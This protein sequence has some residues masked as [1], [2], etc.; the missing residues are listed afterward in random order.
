MI[1]VNTVLMGIYF[2]SKRNAVLTCTENHSFKF[3]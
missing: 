1:K 2:N 3:R